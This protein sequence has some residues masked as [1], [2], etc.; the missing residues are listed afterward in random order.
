MITLYIQ[1]FE[2]NLSLK[3]L[4]SNLGLAPIAPKKW[5]SPLPL[6]LTRARASG[7]NAIAPT[8]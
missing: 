7:G 1:N 4:T 5:F 8:P 6:D 3:Y 2:L